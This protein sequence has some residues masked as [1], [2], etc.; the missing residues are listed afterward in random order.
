MISTLV[1][2]SENGGWRGT[3]HSDKHIQQQAEKYWNNFK[4]QRNLINSAIY[5]QQILKASLYL[6]EDKLR[7]YVLKRFN[8]I[9]HPIQ[10][11]KG[12]LI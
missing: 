5:T 2:K 8:Y 9:L 11:R 1:E 10:D 6:I 3:Y 12:V 7:P 4:L